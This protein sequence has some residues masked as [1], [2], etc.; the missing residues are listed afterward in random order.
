MYSALVL[1]YNYYSWNTTVISP[2]N[3]HPFNNK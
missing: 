1:T 2:I 3:L